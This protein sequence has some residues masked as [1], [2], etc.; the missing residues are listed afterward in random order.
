MVLKDMSINSKLPG[1]GK[2]SRLEVSGVHFHLRSDDIR[3]MDPVRACEVCG[4]ERPSS[5]MINYICVIGSP[6]HHSLL[7]FQHPDEEH[8]ACSF[9]CWLKVHEMVGKEM[10]QLLGEKHQGLSESVHYRNV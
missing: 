1:V 3:Y 4:T 7:P 10:H 8:W 2:I 5:D 6:G 9:E